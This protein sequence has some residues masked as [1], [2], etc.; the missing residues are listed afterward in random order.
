M[1]TS[2]YPFTIRGKM[3][4][5]TDKHPSSEP[6]PLVSNI[7]DAQDVPYQ[8]VIFAV[9]MLSILFCHY[10]LYETFEI[11]PVIIFLV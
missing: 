6:A 4:C 8:F 11:Q 9:R 2:F 1:A 5:Y 3:S 10:I 7:T